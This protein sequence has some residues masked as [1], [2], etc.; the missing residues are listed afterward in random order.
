[1]LQARVYPVHTL[2]VYSLNAIEPEVNQNPRNVIWSNA[3]EGS[4]AIFIYQS[5]PCLQRSEKVFVQI[6][7]FDESLCVYVK[8]KTAMQ[9]HFSGSKSCFDFGFA[10]RWLSSSGQPSCVESQR[11]KAMIGKRKRRAERKGLRGTI[12]ETESARRETDLQFSKKGS[13]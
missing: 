12:R 10:V 5:C 13:Y 1:M 2:G 7:Y 3:T 4:V 9:S 6:L 11:W 8:L